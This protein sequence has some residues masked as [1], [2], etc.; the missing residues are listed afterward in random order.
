MLINNLGCFGF[1]LGLAVDRGGA[2]RGTGECR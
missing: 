1:F 2:A